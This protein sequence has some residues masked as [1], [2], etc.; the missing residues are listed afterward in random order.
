[1][2]RDG[3]CVTFLSGLAEPVGALIGAIALSTLGTRNLIGYS[4][5]FAAGAPTGKE[6]S[7]IMFKSVGACIILT[8][9]NKI[10]YGQLPRG[11]E[12]WIMLKLS[13]TL[14]R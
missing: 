9:R 4:L 8:L 1:M 6:L 7:S 3:A 14:V 12:C 10:E 13:V 5:V 11:V 2:L